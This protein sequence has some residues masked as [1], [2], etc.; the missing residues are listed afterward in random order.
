MSNI[1]IYHRPLSTEDN[2]ELVINVSRLPLASWT[3][4]QSQHIFDA[5][6]ALLAVVLRTHLPAPTLHAMLAELERLAAE[7]AKS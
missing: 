4:Q 2:N 1:L 7:A 6:G 3:V 5:D